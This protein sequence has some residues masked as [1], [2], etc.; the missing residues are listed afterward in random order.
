M[1]RPKEVLR[2]RERV[3]N[4]NPELRER[5]LIKMDAIYAAL[6]S[7]LR[8][9]G[10]DQTTA[11]I[12]TDMAISIW[13]VAA[14]RWLHGD[15]SPFAAEVF[16]AARHLRRTKAIE[17]A[18]KMRPTHPHAISNSA[19]GPVQETVSPGPAAAGLAALERCDGW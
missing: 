2:F 4:A 14:E 10:T 18:R 7:A 5:E 12:A 8:E 1:F 11:R 17:P 6:V 9:R 16:D 3:I 19:R 13:R 15:D